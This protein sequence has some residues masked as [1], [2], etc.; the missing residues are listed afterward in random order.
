MKRLVFLIVLTSFG[1]LYGQSSSCNCNQALTQLIHKVETEYPGFSIKTKEHLSYNDFKEKLM[2]ESKKTIDVNC[3][4]ILKS[5]TDFFKDPH[6]WVGANGTPFSSLVVNRDIISMDINIQ[7][8]KNNIQF[9][10]DIMEGIWSNETYSFGIKKTDTNEYTGF[11]IESKYKEWN[12][13]DIK[14]KL[15]RNGGFEYALL[16]KTIRTG[17]FKLL[18]ECI[19]HLEDVSVVLV[20]NLPKPTLSE[21][22]IKAKLDELNGFYFK[23]LSAK[24]AILKL[25]SFEYQYL[26]TID[27]L[28]EQNKSLLECENLIIDLRGNPGG[29]TEAYQKLLPYISGKVIRNT[30]T[31]FLAT[32]TYIDNL[33]AYKKTLDQNTSTE[34]I[35]NNIKKLKENLGKFVN[36]SASDTSEVYIEKIVVETKCP[37]HIVIF[38]NGQTGSSAEYLLFIAKQSKKVK[39]FGKPSYGALDY[40]NAYLVNLGCSGYQVLSPT[41]RALRLPDY[42]IDNIGIQPDIY[43]DKSVKDWTEFTLDY[44]EQ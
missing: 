23:P 25:P 31:E 29:T 44:L 42:P 43:M 20:K 2:E 34:R 35:D 26:Q 8:F 12:P 13:K 33:E 10:E 16:D 7:D 22:Q 24:T 30:G 11:I 38:A 37:Q 6:L 39:I 9:S 1:A 15:Y 3:P 32:Q 17:E 19:L 36:F 28:I 21:H 27:S 18:N 41:Y 4:G 40:G 5:Y 14:F